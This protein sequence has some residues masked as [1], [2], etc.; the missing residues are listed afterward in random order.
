ME[1]YNNFYEESKKYLN[2]D[3][4]KIQDRKRNKKILSLCGWFLSIIFVVISIIQVILFVL[5]KKYF[6]SFYES[7]WFELTLTA[8]SILGVGLPLAFILMKKIPDSE[9]GE[10]KKL[11]LGEF[12]KYFLICYAAMFYTNLIT[13]FINNIISYFT[14]SEVVNP[15][16]EVILGSNTFII[17]LY[18]TILGPI[19]EELIFRKLLL[20]KLRRFGDLPAI[21]LTSIAFGLFHMNLSQALY[22]TAVGAVMAYVTVKTNT[23]RYSI[24]IHIMVNFIGSGLAPLVL[25]SGDMKIIILISLVIQV[26]VAAGTAFFIINIKKIKFTKAAI[27]LVKKSDYILNSGTIVFIILCMFMIVESV[28]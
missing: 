3:S 25:Y 14:G 27:P 18:A 12:V 24:L 6:I 10:V 8:V 19:A 2:N 22:A 11:S 28:L 21:L 17:I 15:L 26:I 13:L 16:E 1:N 23:I 9:K 20:D 7:D 4:E 5:S